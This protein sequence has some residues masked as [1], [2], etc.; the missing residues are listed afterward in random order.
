MSQMNSVSEKCGPEI[1]NTE[2]GEWPYRNT[3]SQTSGPEMLIRICTTN[4]MLGWSTK[5]AWSPEEGQLSMVHHQLEAIPSS[6]LF[7]PPQMMYSEAEVEN[8][9]L[10]QEHFWTRQCIWGTASRSFCGHM[11][12]KWD[13]HHSCD[14]PSASGCQ[15]HAWAQLPPIQQ[16]EAESRSF[17]RGS[18]M[19]GKHHL[20]SFALPGLS[21]T[22]HSHENQR[23]RTAKAQK[24][25]YDHKTQE[26]LALMPGSSNGTTHVKSSFVVIIESA[27]QKPCPGKPLSPLLE[28]ARGRK[29][30]NANCLPGTGRFAFCI[31]TDIYSLSYS[32]D[33]LNYIQRQRIVLLSV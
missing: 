13:L 10:R 11:K 8:F 2:T 1:C 29:S 31:C 30:Q 26:F 9:S 15:L 3:E 32:L 27:S 18:L 21:R 7:F 14:Y 17:P 19:W 16:G 12:E 28:A 24:G 5:V 33:A 20:P 4:T 6:P 23:W 25:R 22:I